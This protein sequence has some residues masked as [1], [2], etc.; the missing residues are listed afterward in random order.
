MV[1]IDNLS[2]A[3]TITLWSETIK[4]DLLWSTAGKFT[5]TFTLENLSSAEDVYV[6]FKED[7]TDEDEEYVL[8]PWS[9]LNFN[10]SRSWAKNFRVRW[11]NSEKI[12]YIAM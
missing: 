6:S 7:A 10:F 5:K 9:V 1:S 4:F 11:T 2:S 12:S 3:W 8:T